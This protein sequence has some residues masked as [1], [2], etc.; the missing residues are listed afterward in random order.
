MYSILS[1][2]LINNSLIKKED[3][4]SMEE[5]FVAVEAIMHDSEFWESGIG[6]AIG[7]SSMH[8][9][10]SVAN[11]RRM[12][13]AVDNLDNNSKEAAK[14]FINDLKSKG[15]DMSDEALGT[16][17]KQIAV[18]YKALFTESIIKRSKDSAFG[19]ELLKRL[20]NNELGSKPV[21][22]TAKEVVET[23]PVVEAE[24]KKPVGKKT[25]TTPDI[26]WNKERLIDFAL[27]HDEID[28]T[29]AT[30]KKDIFSRIYKSDAYKKTLTAPVEAPIETPAGAASAESFM[31]DTTAPEDQ[32]P[33]G[34]Y[35]DSNV[36]PPDERPSEE[37]FPGYYADQAEQ[38]P[39]SPTPTEEY[40]SEVPGEE[41]PTDAQR[42]QLD[43]DI[44][45]Y[46]HESPPME[47]LEMMANNTIAADENKDALIA[48]G[49]TPNADG[50]YN[51]PSSDVATTAET[52]VPTAR[53]TVDKGDS[54][55]NIYKVLADNGIAKPKSKLTKSRLVYYANKQLE[56]KFKGVGVGEKAV[57]GKPSSIAQEKKIEPPTSQKQGKSGVSPSKGAVENKYEANVKLASEL[58]QLYNVAN[59]HGGKA[60]DAEIKKLEK[61]LESSG[62]EYVRGLENDFYPVDVRIPKP[63]QPTPASKGAVEQYSFIKHAKYKNFDKRFF[64]RIYWKQTRSWVLFR[65]RRWSRTL[66]V[67]LGNEGLLGFEIN[68]IK[69]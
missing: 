4:G 60:V 63:T 47:V 31:R 8:L 42:D 35:D 32:A 28:L 11:K 69:K 44:A 18:Q 65:T 61:K 50:T 5:L 10:G 57:K 21:T 19:E 33:S 25:D 37:P 23:K 51:P 29:G 41:F 39:D 38:Y 67:L 53:I 22:V 24:K 48:N 14:I 27:D 68:L 56:K 52:V 7:G 20:D 15:S 66:Q 36:A 6:G 2:Q 62:V 26:S 59:V 40:P 43:A 1:Q 16:L 58:K 12:N 17:E 30:S 55:T 9:V 49:F 34:I 13:E 54:Y 45:S 64:G 3:Y 46:S